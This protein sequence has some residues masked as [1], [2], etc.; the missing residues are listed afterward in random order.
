MPVKK[1][2]HGTTTTFMADSQIFPEIAY[3]FEALSNRFREMC[4]LN[5]ALTIHF[6]SD[7]HEEM[8]PFNAV[9]YYFDGGVQSFVRALNRRRAAIHDEVFYANETVEGIMV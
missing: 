9:T 4:Y 5:Q 2:S 7:L 1:C 6:R 8:Y 3:D